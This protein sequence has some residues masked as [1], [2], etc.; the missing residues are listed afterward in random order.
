MTSPKLLQ[1]VRK[2][3]VEVV[4]HQQFFKQTAPDDEWL[5]VV[6]Q[7]DWIVVGQDY[8]L[9]K[10]ASELFAIKTFNI[11]VFYLWGAQAS[12][13]EALRSLVRGFDRM[14]AAIEATPRPFVFQIQKDGLLRRVRLP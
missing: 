3:P 1:R 10:N 6:G 12:Q 11:G 14:T 13:W 7:R 8:N 9:H 5:P 4:Y 2:L